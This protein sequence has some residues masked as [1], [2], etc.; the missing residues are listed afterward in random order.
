[1]IFENTDPVE[2]VYPNYT[3]FYFAANGGDVTVKRKLENG[4]WIEVVGSPIADGEE[5]IVITG[6][7][8]GK[9]QVTASIADTQ[10]TYGKEA[11]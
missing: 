3:P 9:L 8:G 1:M 10:L 2:I 7:S 4:T 11:Q 5:T 6:S